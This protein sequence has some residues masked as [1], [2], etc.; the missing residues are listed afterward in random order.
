MKKALWLVLMV[1]GIS[2]VPV[3]AQDCSKYMGKG[4]CVDYIKERLGSRPRGNA[5][6]WN[7]NI[8][9][10]DVRPGDA[11]IFSSPRPWG[12]VAIVERV[13]YEHNT[14]TPYQIEISEW[15]WGPKMVDAGC[16]VTNKFGQLTRRTVRVNTVKGYWRP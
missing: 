4:Y 6:T 13:I 12:H 10:R 2:C 7:G 11:A 9:P 8:N 15:N 3:A 14:A 16:A 5:G 1:L